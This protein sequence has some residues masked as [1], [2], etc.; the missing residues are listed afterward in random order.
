MIIKL[1]P[2]G[3]VPV[4]DEVQTPSVKGITAYPNP[5]NRYT[6]I[7]IV[8]DDPT[9]RK[10][11]IDIFNIK[12]QLV[13]SLKPVNNETNWDGKDNAGLSC[14]SGVYQVLFEERKKTSNQNY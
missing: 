12:R 10:E 4:E 8:H 5:M 14:P 1:L 7:R 3:Q 6:N 13:R 9:V 11:R 2:N